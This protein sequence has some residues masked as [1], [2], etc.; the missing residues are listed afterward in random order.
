MTTVRIL[1]GE[2]GNYLALPFFSRNS[3]RSRTALKASSVRLH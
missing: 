1:P 2:P 3:S